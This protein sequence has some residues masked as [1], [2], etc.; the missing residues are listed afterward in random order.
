MGNRG[1]IEKAKTYRFTILVRK[2]F[3]HIV[4]RHKTT[5]L[6]VPHE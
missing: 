6:Q 4:K 1:G 5:M 3:L 2:R